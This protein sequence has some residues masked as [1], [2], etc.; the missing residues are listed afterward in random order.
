M[1]ANKSLL[2]VCSLGVLALLVLAAARENLFKDWRRIQGSARS[3]AGPIE[4]RLRQIVVPVL[5]V[6]DRCTSCH[7]GMAAVFL[8]F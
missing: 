8:F 7:V 3:S 2:L 6:T 5:H 1:K 4:V